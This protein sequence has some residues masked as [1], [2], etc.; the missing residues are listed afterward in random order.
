MWS[1][2]HS[3]IGLDGPEGLGVAGSGSTGKVGLGRNGKALR[4]ESGVAL[5]L[6]GLAG[7]A[8]CVMAVGYGKAG[9]ASIVLT[10]RRLAAHEM[11]ERGTAG[12]T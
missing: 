3:R 1:G 10:R 4:G 8:G 5:V 11:A 7:E 12:S 9:L 2:S 6:H